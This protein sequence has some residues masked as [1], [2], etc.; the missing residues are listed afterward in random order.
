[1]MRGW[2]SAVVALFVVAC[3]SACGGRIAPKLEA[4]ADAADVAQLWQE[5]TDLETRNL[6]WGPG[7]EALA[8][9]PGTAFAFVKADQTGYSPGYDVRGPDGMMWSVKLGSEAQPEVVVSRILWA[10]GFHQVPTYYVAEWKLTGAPSNDG[11]TGIPGPGRFR[12]EVPGR[13]VVGEWS[14][15]E[16]EFVETQPFR[17]LVVINVLLNNWDWKTSNNKIYEVEGGGREF[18]V[19]DLGASLGKTAYPKALSWFPTKGLGQ[20]SRNDLED[21]EEQGFIKSVDGDRVEFVYRGIHRSL[22]ERV[23]RADVVWAAQLL[24]RLSEE[25]WSDAFRAAQYTDEQSRRYVSKIK[26]KIAEGIALRS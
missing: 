17:G 14:W 5:P 22:I 2:S 4:S 9:D 6:F 12:P 26:S 11:A 1:M 3:A 16:N 20:G 25:Q 13:T 19:R 10:V 24:A 15:Y 23:S 7:G 8:P 21:F 18:V